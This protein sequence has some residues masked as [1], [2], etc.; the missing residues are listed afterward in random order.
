MPNRVRI[1][2]RDILPG[3]YFRVDGR[4]GRRLEKDP[5]RSQWSSGTVEMIEV[6]WCDNGSGDLLDDSTEVDA[7]EAL[8]T[9]SMVM[10]GR[11]PEDS[12]SAISAAMD[13]IQA[14]TRML[15]EARNIIHAGVML[16]TAMHEAGAQR[17]E[18]D[19]SLRAWAKSAVERM[20]A[21]RC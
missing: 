12:P 14:Q 18:F 21:A 6:Q 8:E 20:G 10:R 2:L 13:T 17:R 4:V 3:R 16:V 19:E 11:L 9:A 7:V 1:T 15:V 5:I